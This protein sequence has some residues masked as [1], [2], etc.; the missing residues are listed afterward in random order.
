MSDLHELLDRWE[1]EHNEVGAQARADLEKVIQ[2]HTATLTN[3]VQQL[4]KFVRSVERDWDCDQ[5][6]H[7]YGTGCRCCEAEELLK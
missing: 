5:D 6:G 4:E 1:G 2:Q 3:R 7:K